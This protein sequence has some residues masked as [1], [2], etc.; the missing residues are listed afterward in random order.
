MSALWEFL[1]IETVELREEQPG[2]ANRIHADLPAASVRC[3][4]VC[5][6]VNPHESEMSWHNRKSSWLRDNRRIGAN[7]ACNEI[8][9]PDTFIFFVHDCRDHDLDLRRLIDGARGGRAHR[10][11]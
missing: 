7:A 9:R 2:V 4:A 10:G 5:R 6:D 8:T 11:H 3:S 1:G